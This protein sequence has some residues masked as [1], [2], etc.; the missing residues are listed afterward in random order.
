MNGRCAYAQR[1]FIANVPIL[2][3]I[4]QFNQNILRKPSS[5][6][7]NQQLQLTQNLKSHNEITR[8]F[9]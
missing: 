2:L 6:L 3:I 7:I 9:H 4:E 8:L 1:P 5:T